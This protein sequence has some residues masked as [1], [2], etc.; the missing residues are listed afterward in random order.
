MVVASPPLSVFESSIVVFHHL[1]VLYSIFI[2]EELYWL[3]YI[4]YTT[5]YIVIYTFIKFLFFNLRYCMY[6]IL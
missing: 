2:L 1:I 3:P 6:Y 4:S 5:R